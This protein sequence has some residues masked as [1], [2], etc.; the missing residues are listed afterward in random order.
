MRIFFVG[1]GRVPYA[2][3]ACDIRLDSFAELFVKCGAT[4]TVINRYSSLFKN[5]DEYQTHDYEVKEL[6]PH[7]KGGMIGKVLFL[8]SIIKEFGYLLNYRMKKG[9]NA[10]LHIY[11]GHFLDIFF[12][13]FIS[14]I[15]SYKIVYQ[16]VEYRLDEKRRN[17]YHILNAWLVDKLSARLWDGCISISHFL[18]ERALTVNSKLKTVIGPPICDFTRFDQFRGVKENIVLYCGSA[19]YFEVIKFVVDSFNQSKLSASYKLELI[20]AGNKFQI[21]EVRKYAS[22][23]IIKTK[24]PYEELIKSYNHSKILMIPLRNSIKDISR[25]PNKV[26]EYAASKS[27]IVTTCFGEPAHFFNDKKSA[28]IAND[29]SVEAMVEALDWLADNQNAIPMIG[30]EGYKEGL[31][32]FHIEAYIG[33]MTAFLNSI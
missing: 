11:S 22:N 23:A 27:V 13:W 19:G 2:S 29:Y 3:R 33:K 26:C 15:C 20:V 9:S 28:M 18:Q 12:Y 21:E 32:A 25:F 6:V 8:Y 24:L 10:I 1:L 17:P 4:V 7:S 16:Y 31:N 30:E 5:V 14:K